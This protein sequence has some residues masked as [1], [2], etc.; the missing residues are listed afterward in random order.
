MY[1]FS[2]SKKYRFW[3]SWAQCNEMCIPSQFRKNT[4]I[5]PVESHT[6][7]LAN[8]EIHCYVIFERSHSLLTVF[9]PLVDIPWFVVFITGESNIIVIVKV[10]RNGG[11]RHCLWFWWINDEKSNVWKNYE[12]RSPK[13]ERFTREIYRWDLPG[14]IYK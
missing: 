11:R 14:K 3:N 6:K 12:N 7:F 8:E 4:G 2:N 1:F 13:W 10:R 9:F 5:A